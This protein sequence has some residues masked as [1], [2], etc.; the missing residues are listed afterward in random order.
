MHL[1]E[2]TTPKRVDGVL[3]D[4][5]ECVGCTVQSVLNDGDAEPV[6][7]DERTSLASARPCGANLFAHP[8]SPFRSMDE[9][10][11][12]GLRPETRVLRSN[13][14]GHMAGVSGGGTRG[15]DGRKGER[16]CPCC[17]DLHGLG[18][19]GFR[20]VR[21]DRCVSAFENDVRLDR[22]LELESNP[23]TAEW[24]QVTRFGDGRPP[25]V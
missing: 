5:G 19:V 3:H 20:S 18:P 22:P 12:D 6:P 9:Q 4:E 15:V 24:R 16:V 11:P 2:R 17:Q 21:R 25:F 7:T 13:R 23:G 14:C 8:R 10:P 1:A